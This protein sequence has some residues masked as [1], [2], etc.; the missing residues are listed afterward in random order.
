MKMIGLLGGMSWESTREYYRLLNEGVREAKGGLHS[1]PILLHSFD[2]AQIARLQHAGRW[3]VLAD[4][5]A[6]AAQGLERAGAGAIM[7]CTNLMHKVAPQVQAAI[8]IPLLHIADAVAAS[9][10][11]D[12]IDCV[13]LLGA[14]YTMLEPFYRDRL[15]THGIRTMVPEA[16][17]LE[18]ISRVVYDELCQGQFLPESRRFYVEAIERLIV[19]GAKG[20][21]LG[22]TEIP[23]L[24]AQKDV[25]IPIYDTTAL[26]A[27]AGLAFVLSPALQAESA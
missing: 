21:V 10:K 17:D 4:M 3:D 24:I 6:G 9:I 25:R 7:I 14:R 2:F 19:R 20:V 27:E 16:E 23:Q 22:C 12:G 11:A 15:S 13:A 18:E 8:S 1:A 5:L 26:H